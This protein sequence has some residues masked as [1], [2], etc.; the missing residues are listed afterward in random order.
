MCDKDFR[1]I[2]SDKGNLTECENALQIVKIHYKNAPL[3][4]TCKGT[5]NL[6][7]TKD[8][9]ECRKKIVDY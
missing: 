6:H 4:R 3:N 5:L 7:E 9:I 8:D 2:I 1:N